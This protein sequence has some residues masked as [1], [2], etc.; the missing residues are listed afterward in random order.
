MAAEVAQGCP[1]GAMYGQSLS[2]ALAAYLAGQYSV[3]KPNRTPPRQLSAAQAQRVVGYIHAN[4]HCNMHLSDLADLV[5]LSPRQ[6]FRTFSNS[7]GTTPHQYIM[8]K[9]VA[10]AKG[11]LSQGQ[12]LV[13][14]AALLGFAS[15][16]HF[17]GV[18]RR[19]TGLSPGRF[20]QEHSG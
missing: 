13:E 20:R 8:N 12:S 17:C 6:F 9:R 19:A 3:K 10:E 4:L 7:F 5:Q 18:F 2:L 11:L 15:Q 16:S 14:V 1:A